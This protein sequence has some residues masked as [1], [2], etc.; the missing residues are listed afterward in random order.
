[1]LIHLL[2]RHTLQQNLPFSRIP[3]LLRLDTARALSLIH[4]LFRHN[5]PSSPLPSLH[6]PDMARALSAILLLFLRPSLNGPQLVRR[7]VGRL[8][9]ALRRGLPVNMCQVQSDRMRV[10]LS[11]PFLRQALRPEHQPGEQ[12]RVSRRQSRAQYPRWRLYPHPRHKEP[13]K[14]AL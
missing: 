8:H 3:S 2:L 14:L 5:L 12:I 11:N 10:V 9:L 1:M 6:R 13:T 4:P 7:R